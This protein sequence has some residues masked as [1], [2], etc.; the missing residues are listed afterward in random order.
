MLSHPWP[1]A[2][3]FWTDPAPL[4]VFLTTISSSYFYK[5]STKLSK[6]EQSSDLACMTKN[7]NMNDRKETACEPHS[8]SVSNKNMV[9]TQLR[10]IRQLLRSQSFEQNIFMRLALAQHGESPK[11]SFLSLL[12]SVTSQTTKDFASLYGFVISII[13]QLLRND[14][15]CFGALSNLNF[16][17][18]IILNLSSN[19]IARAS[20]A[21][22]PQLI[23]AIALNI[24]GRI[25]VQNS[26]LIE[27]VFKSLY[28]EEL[29][30]S[31][32][33]VT[34]VAASNHFGGSL[35]ELLT[36]HPLLRD[37]VVAC[38]LTTLDTIV[39]IFECK[40]NDEFLLGWSFY[41]STFFLSL[42]ILCADETPEISKRYVRFVQCIVNGFGPFLSL[43]DDASK[44]FALDGG[45][46][47]LF[48]LLSSPASPLDYATLCLLQRVIF[49]VASRVYDFNFFKQ[50]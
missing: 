23:S 1:G 19:V 15:T 37:E 43:N 34:M 49:N 29:P 33:Q 47:L 7:E 5:K 2:S 17:Q 24:R 6:V 36:H 4:N 18:T 39:N 31:A 42:T 16:P 20:I 22:I 45:L 14:S 30:P 13:S 9:K 12:L 44:K 8:L 46:D 38:S 28:L 25:M 48:K 11:T 32:D 26:G 3:I 50:Y 10:F 40:E 21:S 27:N 35:N 41:P